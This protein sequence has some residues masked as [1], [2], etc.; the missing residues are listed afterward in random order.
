MTFLWP[1]RGNKA[2]W[3][4]IWAKK[5]FFFKKYFTSFLPN[6][7]HS[8]RIIVIPSVLLS[9]LPNYC[10]SFRIR[11]RK[12]ARRAGHICEWLHKNFGP[13]VINR[14]ARVRPRVTNKAFCTC[15]KKICKLIPKAVQIP[16]G[17]ISKERSSKQICFFCTVLNLDQEKY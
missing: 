14:F 6:Y 16:Y 1:S 17:P 13:I 2:N 5:Y 8:F 12:F 9:F 7:C 10:H 3:G 15:A 4:N 11:V